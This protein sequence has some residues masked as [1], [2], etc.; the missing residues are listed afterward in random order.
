VIASLVASQDLIAL[1]VTG[2]GPR[3]E[4]FNAGC[5]TRLFGH[6][7]KLVAINALV[8]SPQKSGQR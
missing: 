5:L 7:H 8:T 4:I 2:V 6:L 1:D 3:R